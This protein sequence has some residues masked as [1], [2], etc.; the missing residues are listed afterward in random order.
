VATLTGKA[1]SSSL[2][3]F[4]HQSLATAAA[5]RGRKNLV[6]EQENRILALIEA[7]EKDQNPEHLL[8]AIAVLTAMVNAAARLSKAMAAMSAPGG[9]AG[10]PP[11]PAAVEPRA[12]GLAAAPAGRAAQSAREQVRQSARSLVEAITGAQHRL[13]HAARRSAEGGIEQMVQDALQSS[14][15]LFVPLL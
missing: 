10:P 14:S 7:W 8:Q 2:S 9:S 13:E 5:I 15:Y 3:R 4:Q 1:A 11:R 6:I 12:G